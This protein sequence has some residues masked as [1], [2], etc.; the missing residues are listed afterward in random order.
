MEE[1]E[2]DYEDKKYYEY[3]TIIFKKRS[4]GFFFGV[5]VRESLINKVK[6]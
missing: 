1:K 2:K 6:N 4:R 5:T 3:K